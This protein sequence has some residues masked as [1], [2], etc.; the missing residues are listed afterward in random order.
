MEERPSMGRARGRGRGDQI[1][2]SNVQPQ[3]GS[4]HPQVRKMLWK[5]IYL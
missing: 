3:L 2:P 5:Y 1:R 4:A